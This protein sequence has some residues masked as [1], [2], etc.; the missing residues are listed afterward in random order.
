MKR[1]GILLACLFVMTWSAQAQEPPEMQLDFVRKLRDKG[2]VDLALEYLEGLNKSAPPALKAVLPME[3]AR[4]RIALARDKPPDQRLALIKAART[5]LEIFVKSFAD[6]PEGVQA[7]L[8]LARLNTQEGK[9]ILSKALRQDDIKTQQSEV[10]AAENLF[11]RA[12]QDLDAAA[13]LLANLA[14]NY[15][16][17][18]PKQEELIRTQLAQ[19]LLTARLDRGINLMEQTRTYINVGNEV[20]L[21]QRAEVNDQARKIFEKLAQEEDAATKPTCL[22]AAAWLV[23]CFQ[24]SQSPKEAQDY[25]NLVMKQKKKVADSAKRWARHF[26]MQ[27]VLKDIKGK[28]ADQ[29]LAKLNDQKKLKTLEDEA[30][31][32]LAAYPSHLNSPEGQGV[33]WELANCYIQEALLLGKGDLKSPKAA[34]LAAKAQTLLASLAEGDSD[35]AEQAG[36]LSITLNV[37]RIA[38]VPLEKLKGFD[39]PYLKGHYEWNQVKK[40]VAKLAD[41]ELKEDV[42]KKLVKERH[43]RLESAIRAFA[44][45]LAR[46]SDKTPVSKKDDARFF[47]VMAYLELGDMHRAA[48]AGE[49]LARQQPPRKRAAAAAGYALEAYASILAR[50]NSDDNRERLFNLANFI[51]KDQRKYW[52]HEPVTAVSHY[53]LAA[54]YQRDAN[55]KDAI[56]QLEQLNDSYPGFI[57]AQGQLVFFALEARDKA[58]NEKDKKF[59]Q[60][61]ALA[62]LK[63]IPKLPATTDASTA[64]MFFFAQME[65]PKWL[66]RQAA[67][68]LAESEVIYNKDK[69]EQARAK[70][71][72]QAAAKY[73]EMASF[74]KQLQD[75]LAKLPVKISAEN[76]NKLMFTLGV[77]EK[78]SRLGQAEIEYRKGNYDA[79]LSPPLTGAVLAE[80][81]KL[82]AK[83]GPIQMAEYKVVGDILTLALR[84]G[85]QKGKIAEAK[86]TLGLIQRLTSNEGIQADPNAVLRSLVQD[87]E[88]QVKALKKA[89][90]Q[91]KL[92]TFVGNFSG[93]VDELVK[94]AGKG[95]D[96][97]TFFFL[98]RLYD[99]LDL[100]Q[101][102]AD[103]YAKIP[104]PKALAKPKGSKFTEEEEKE[105]QSYWYSQVQYAHQLHQ[106]G[107]DDKKAHLEKAN[108]VILTL[109][110]HPHARAHQLAEIEKIHIL[111][112]KE[113]YG[114]AATQWEKFMKNPALAKQMADGDQTAKETYFDAYYQM[115][116]CIYKYSRSD[117]AKTR[118]LDKAYLR[119]AADYIV[120]LE[121]ANNSEGWELLRPR[122]EALME[123]E[124]PLRD[125]VEELKKKLKKKTAR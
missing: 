27:R 96:P 11:I 102:A 97:A 73:K 23:R 118:K 61:K 17:P 21:R 108:Q 12:G 56:A 58:K 26:H 25:F 116:Y 51:L 5:E 95:N 76:K 71:V 65:Y 110:R 24:E 55:W 66:F 121:N 34:P 10:K 77:L 107:G 124:L 6:R 45:A 29:G 1:I 9:A 60:G 93:L 18:D 59:F 91:A 88:V 2:Y 57:Y 30:V 54:T 32:W 42:K 92:K 89:N 98:A 43:D 105:I 35:F 84:A 4:T 99:S 69:A 113:I 46:A 74:I 7:R 64:T 40:V 48:V 67:A 13:K 119:R 39:D 33:R 101:K 31:K 62:A 44:Q 123:S 19:D 20:I 50:D 103:M 70:L 37:N 122:F 80:V 85:V 47:R 81:R 8:E 114:P 14:A 83:P 78:Y 115:T 22:M 63:R 112:E 16:N 41:P 117:G 38:N 104:P 36:Q 86:A 53:K 125:M 100:H 94:G 87:L 111:Q 79:V 109:L 15:K 28:L 120:K 3:L 68:D 82:G 106:I 90:D 75:Q 52:V 49:A 72:L